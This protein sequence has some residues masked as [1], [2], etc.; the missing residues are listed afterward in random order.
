MKTKTAI[1]SGASGTQAISRRRLLE[2]AGLAAIAMPP[3]AAAAGDAPPAE[4]TGS[5]PPASANCTARPIVRHDYL[6]RHQAGVVTPRPLAGMAVALDVRARDRQALGELLR[7][8]TRRIALL[9]QGSI[10]SPAPASPGQTPASLGIAVPGGDPQ[11]LTITL[12]VGASL[13]D[14]RFGLAPAR[15]RQLQPMMRFANDALDDRLSHGDLC[16][17]LCAQ[18]PDANVNALLDLLRH[19]QGQLAPRW[20]QDGT[21]APSAPP[22][23]GGLAASPRNLMGFRDGSANPDASDA[24]LMDDVVWV[25]PQHGEPAWAHGGSYQVVRIIR[26][27][28]ERWHALAQER[29]EAIFGRQKESG[30]P[31]AT[32]GQTEHHPP[33]YFDDPQG[34]ATPLDSHV[35]L[36]NP[37]EPGNEAHLMLRRPFNYSNGVLPSGQLDLGLLFICYQADLEQA[38]VTVQRRLDGEP[39]EAFVQPIG[40][41]FFFTLPGVERN[42][43]FLGS[44]LL[45]ATA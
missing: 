4:R 9:T 21:V 43:D 1:H 32:E 7:R 3:L 24:A 22:Q 45:A 34:M 39:L 36:A 5:A 29:Q 12:S 11:G 28:L 14:S 20:K 38:F 44:S 15:P 25:G 10:S 37:R 18:T 27:R 40:G 42:A 35:R 30:A 23:P 2:G 6:G 31:L 13:F 26:N 17:Q 41:G 8:L 16:I 19:A 33:L